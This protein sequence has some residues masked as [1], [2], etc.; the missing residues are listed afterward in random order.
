MSALA[1]QA[2]RDAVALIASENLR[3]SEPD[4]EALFLESERLLA[5]ADG[6]DGL[7][8]DAS[9][10]VVLEGA[11]RLLGVQGVSSPSERELLEAACLVDVALRG[12][13]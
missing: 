5:A 9:N 3:A 12:V 4:E 7:P 2:T 8:A 11:E 1:S 10:R 13:S 6:R